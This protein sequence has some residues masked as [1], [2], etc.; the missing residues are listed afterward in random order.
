MGMGYPSACCSSASPQGYSSLAP[1]WINLLCNF[2]AAQLNLVIL[3]RL[4]GLICRRLLWVGTVTQSKARNICTL[5]IRRRQ[6]SAQQPFPKVPCIVGKITLTGG[7]DGNNYNRMLCQ[8]SLRSISI[9]KLRLPS[10]MSY[11]FGGVEGQYLCREMKA[12]YDTPYLFRD[13]MCRARLRPIQHE[14]GSTDFLDHSRTIR[15][16]MNMR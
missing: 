14:C 15:R 5:Q 9:I 13:I 2:R 12:L 1:S 16:L 7:G 4:R 6:L 3:D 8:G 11:R 10:W